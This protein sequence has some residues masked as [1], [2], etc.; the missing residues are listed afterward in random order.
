LA[1]EQN[2][3]RLLPAHPR[4]AKS[5]TSVPGWRNRQTSVDLIIEV[6]FSRD[7][8]NTVTAPTIP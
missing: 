1:K 2:L 5:R 8:E 4:R 3:S 6:F 7:V